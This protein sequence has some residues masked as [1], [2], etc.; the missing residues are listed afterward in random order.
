MNAAKIN[1]T[2]ALAKPA[3]AHFSASAG[4]RKAGSTRAVGPYGSRS[5]AMTVTPISPMAGAG[6]GSGIN[7]RMTVTNAAKY[8]HA[9]GGSP[10]G[11][12]LSAPAAPTASGNP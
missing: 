10:E 1:Q 11:P 5:T 9:C 12:G 8:S 7:E 3:S 4:A 6:S 2:V